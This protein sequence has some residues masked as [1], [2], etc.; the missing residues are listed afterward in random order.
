[1]V[2]RAAGRAAIDD[3]EP[4]GLREGSNRPKDRTNEA[5]T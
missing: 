4:T 1:M 5:V 2:N 3:D